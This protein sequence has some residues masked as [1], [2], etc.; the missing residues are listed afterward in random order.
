MFWTKDTNQPGF[1]VIDNEGQPLVTG[2]GVVLSKDYSL[3]YEIQGHKPVV[4]TASGA[5]LLE[6]VSRV[7]TSVEWTRQKN[8]FIQISRSLNGFV[9][10][11]GTMKISRKLFWEVSK[12]HDPQHVRLV[13]RACKGF[14]TD[15]ANLR[16]MI[17]AY[18]YTKLMSRDDEC[19]C[20]T[21]HL[22]DIPA[23]QEFLDDI[24]KNWTDFPVVKRG[25]LTT[26]EEVRTA[27]S[28]GYLTWNWVP[29]PKDVVTIH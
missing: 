5:E 10:L 17:C 16:M 6:S 22:L 14:R 19:A 27:F 1:L 15:K 23:D 13:K 12:R 29:E 20:S 3:V 11:W 18:F 28:S 26:L 8:E 21:L 2:D 25:E 24:E 9:T 4:F 7:L